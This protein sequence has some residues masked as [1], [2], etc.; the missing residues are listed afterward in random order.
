MLAV[1]SKLQKMTAPWSEIVA[2]KAFAKA[3]TLSAGNL[4]VP[5]T[6]RIEARLY[7]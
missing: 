6:R 7:S 5:V 3:I 1:G 2:Y 4:H